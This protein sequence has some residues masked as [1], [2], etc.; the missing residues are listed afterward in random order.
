MNSPALIPGKY[1]VT[2]RYF[3]AN[4]M[5]YFRWF[6]N[7]SNGGVTTFQFTDAQVPEVAVALYSSLPNDIASVNATTGEITYKTKQGLQDVVLY[8]SLDITEMREYPF[9]ITIDDPAANNSKDFRVQID[10]I[11]FEPIN[12]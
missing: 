8:E 1:K 10:Y 3:Y 12:E 11:L 7:G 5:R 2:L 4:S 6:G 9:R